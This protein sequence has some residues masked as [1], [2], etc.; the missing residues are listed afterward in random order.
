M[1]GS[2]DAGE[3]SVDLLKLGQEEFEDL[4]ALLGKLV[5]ALPAIVFLAPFAFEEALGFKAAE[6]RVKSAFVDLDAERS[7][8][9]AEGIAVM[10]SPELGEDRDDEQAAAQFQ[11]EIIEEIGI[12]LSRH[13]QVSNTM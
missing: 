7:K 6:E 2:D 5:E 9:L 11:P 10:L 4:A 12:R 3:R 1:V 13:Y 8:V